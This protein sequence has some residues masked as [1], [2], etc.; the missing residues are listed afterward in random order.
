MP[1]KTLR[2]TR[3]KQGGQIPTECPRRNTPA[4]DGTAA[5]RVAA[6]IF[7]ATA[8]FSQDQPAAA[9][10]VAVAAA[11]DKT[12]DLIITIGG[13]AEYGPIYPG[14]SKSG[15]GGMPS[16]D[17]RRFGEPDENS[18]P[19][20][21][22][23]YGLINL[24][25]FEAGP[26]LGIR[27]RRSISDD[28]RLGGLHTI[29][30]GIDLGIFAQYWLVPDTIR[31]RTEVRQAVSNGSGLA[32]DVGADWFIQPAEGWT[33]SIG[34]RLSFGNGRYMKQYFSVS[35]AEAAANGSVGAFQASGGLKSVGATISASYNI[36]PS[37]TI[38]LYDRFDR[39]VGDASDS[40]V[41]RV[42]GSENQNII[43][44]S[45]SKSFAITF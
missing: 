23:D 2:T 25:R 22:L 31:L 12:P 30:W 34:P 16:F 3:C 7:L 32:V 20:D 37:W 24:G 19:D 26:V 5:R 29:D 11:T 14:S 41:T 18:A 21:N 9:A 6:F 15:F 8:A 17:I 35:D 1:G 40:P 42:F 33:F 36:T 13:S 43:G 27:D 44:I 39:L 45:L 4:A 38:E 10:D 28:T